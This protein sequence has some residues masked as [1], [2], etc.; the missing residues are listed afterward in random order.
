MYQPGSRLTLHQQR[1]KFLQTTGHLVIGFA[2]L[3]LPNCTASRVQHT[4]GAPPPMPPL[5]ASSG[6]NSIDSWIRLDANGEVTV[7]TGKMEL[8]QGVRT[9]LMQIAAEELD[10][11]M[12]RVSVIIADTGQT[13][14]ERYTAGS[15]SIESSGTS[16]RNAAAEAR[17]RLLELASQKLHVPA[18]ELSVRNGLISTSTGKS[19]IT[20][21]DLI[22]GKKLEGKISAN[23][24]VKDPSTYKLVG[25]GYP[26]EDITAM[27]TCSY[28][29]IHDLRMPGM[30]HARVVRPPSYQSKLVSVPI[31]AISKLEGVAKV[32]RNGNFLAVIAAKEYQAIKAMNATKIAANWESAS[33][34]PLQEVLFDHM[35]T[36]GVANEAVKED[37][38]VESSLASS[39]FQHEAVYKRPY[40]MHASIGPSCAVA[41]WKDNL[42][43]IWSHTQGVYPMRQTLSDL[44]SIPEDRIR[45]IG[46]P[47]SGCYGH[48]GADDVGADAAL[49]AK[50]MP[51]TPI[52]VQWM[53]DDEHLWE[54]YGS[55]MMIRL[56]AG[57]D[58][59]GKV[60]VWKSAIWSDTH[61][62][63]PG[64]KAGH[65]IAGR[66]LEKS[67]PFSAGGF[68]GG[69]V[70]NS[71]P[72]YDIPAKQVQLFNYK[73][74]LRT[75]ALRSLGAYANIF[76]IESF[77][78][79]LANK[80]EKDPIEFRL[81]QLKDERARAVISKLA[82]QVNWADRKSSIGTGI[83]FAF[84]QYKNQAAYFAVVAEIQI[85]V[86]RKKFRLVKLT[87]CIDAGQVINRDGVINQTEGGMIQSA[88]WT[89]FEEVRYS[90]E[91]ITSSGWDTYPII[92]FSDVPEIE[93]VV[94]D[95]PEQQPLGAGEAAQAPTAAAIANAI[96]N[97][98]G[99]RV[100]D[101][102]LTPNKIDWSR[103]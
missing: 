62:T 88:S 33:L 95:R 81:A 24:V 26:R 76:A 16:I 98:T 21:W 11:D 12:K 6:A 85:D 30:M 25:T 93:V 14:N 38:A 72:L 8:G 39:Q 36:N 100:R 31:E 67:F 70:R 58:R 57:F 92:R 66:H 90:A 79:E 22:Q 69:S 80:L 19:S 65:F 51:G 64:G 18:A 10:V 78:D 59:N 2:I 28:S 94:I 54:P 34:N 73:G 47:G 29:Y 46:V 86:E 3:Q 1:R 55:A 35:V 27:A 42:L 103:I 50:E 74:P 68:S 43:T 97:A 63:R 77:M 56:K 60:Q 32:V 61:S 52:R 101:L 40:H 84:S 15:A 53:R 49:L 45:V 83:G 82:K 71:V 7:L 20:Y 44:L 96:Y 5:R 87:G 48:N 91:A 13:P 17:K 89:L 99:T 23:I 75:S 41:L 4:A 102:P 37:P 9:A